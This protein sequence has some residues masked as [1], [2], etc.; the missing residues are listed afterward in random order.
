MKPSASTGLIPKGI[1]EI[2]NDPA[3]LL[4]GLHVEYI[5]EGEAKIVDLVHRQARKQR[6]KK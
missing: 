3:A 6:R 2:V 4:G 5:E 1:S